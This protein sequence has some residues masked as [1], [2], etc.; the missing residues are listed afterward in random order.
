MR[1]TQYLACAILVLTCAT[2]HAA[3]KSEQP[4]L[5]QKVDAFVLADTKGNPRSL[6]DFAD[7]DIV[8]LAFLGTDCP[9]AKLYAP[10]L[11]RLAKE[12]AERGVAVVGVDS[13]QQDAPSKIDHYVRTHEL[14]FPVLKDLGNKLADALG[15]RRTPEVFVLD[16]QRVVR[17]AGRI[18]DQYGIRDGASYQSPEPRRRD[19][20]EA[21]DELLAGNEVRVPLTD[22][23]GCLIG[24]VREPKADAEVTYSSHIAA[25]MNQNCIYCHREGQ[26]APFPLTSYDEVVGWAEMI[27]EVTSDRR[28]PPWHADPRYG[29]FVNDA[30][31]SDEDLQ[32]IQTWVAAGAPEGNPE[33]LPEAPKFAEGWLIPEPDQVLYMADEPYTIPAEGTVPY[34][35]ITVDPGWTEDKWIKAIEPRP[36]NPSVVHHIVMYIQPPGGPKRGAAGQLRNDW[37]AAY[38]PGLRPQVLPD[39]IARYA[40]AGSKLTFQMHYTPNGSEQKDLSYIGLV[41]ADPKT[42]KR[43]LAVKNAGNF[44]F[45]IPPHADNFEVTSEYVFRDDTLLWSLSPHMHVRGKDFLYTAI[46]PDGRKE[47]LLSV[48]NY[49]FGWQTTYVFNE[50]KLMPKGAKLHC[51]AHYDNSENNLNNPDPNATVRWG[52]Q[53]WE[54]MMFGWFEMALANQDLT[55]SQE[56]IDRMKAFYATLEAGGATMDEQL[57]EAARKALDRDEDYQFFCYYL[58]DRLPQIDR[59]CITYEQDGKLRVRAVEEL[60]GMKTTLRSTSTVLPAK[61]EALTSALES[62]EPV[63]YDDLSQAPGSL[64]QRIH[65][66]GLVSSLHVPVRLEGRAATVNFWSADP[67]GFPTPAV[68][69]LTAVAQQLVAGR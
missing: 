55:Q 23:S 67:K 25:I 13:N 32:A 50:P 30:R 33:D 36:G 46:F 9:L 22:V 20:A 8:V 21:L 15:A 63:V 14:D 49:D 64:A 69:L 54:E 68:E 38:A 40:P 28:M 35:H 6:A 52:E 60:N 27:D 29:H 19:L 10:R 34:I 5:G 44:S 41:F 53:T 18:D 47:V 43:E 26:L 12:Y 7:R 24:R 17:Y 51:V 3:N 16:R 66:R 57:R 56:P 42:V 4:R 48:P 37:F 31:L 2:A 65:A 61:G 11:N 58:S 45:I 62:K 1:L 59:V 39:G